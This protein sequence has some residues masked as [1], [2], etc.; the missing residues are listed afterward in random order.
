MEQKPIPSIVDGIRAPTFKNPPNVPQQSLVFAARPQFRPVDMKL[1]TL[2]SLIA[3]VPV[4][5]ELDDLVFDGCLF[6]ERPA[7]QFASKNCVSTFCSPNT[8]L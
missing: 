7:S 5:G 3:R 4:E 2:G 6:R 8:F 1:E